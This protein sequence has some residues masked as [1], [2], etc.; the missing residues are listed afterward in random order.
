MTQQLFVVV[1]VLNLTHSGTR[2][3]Y[4][5]S[6]PYP[7]NLPFKLTL[8]TPDPKNVLNYTKGE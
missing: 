6:Y 1:N 4:L 2:V 3:K 7:K 5:D 8:F